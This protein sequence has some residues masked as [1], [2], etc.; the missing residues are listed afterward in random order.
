MVYMGNIIKAYESL[1]EKREQNGDEYEVTL[2]FG[3]NLSIRIQETDEINKVN[4][5]LEIIREGV[6][7]I[8]IDTAFVK[9]ISTRKRWL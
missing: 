5:D 9:Y 1:P 8:I 6:C 7:D 4:G 3:D 2:H